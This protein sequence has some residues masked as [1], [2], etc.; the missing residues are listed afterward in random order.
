MGV[1]VSLRFFTV[2]LFYVFWEIVHYYLQSPKRY[3]LENN[4]QIISK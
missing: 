4:S 2:S 1:S 3:T